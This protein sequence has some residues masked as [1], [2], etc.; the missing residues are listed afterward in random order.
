MIY[1]LDKIAQGMANDDTLLY[2]VEVSQYQ[3]VSK[4]AWIYID[5]TFFLNSLLQGS[6]LLHSNLEKIEW[7]LFASGTA[8]FK[9]HKTLHY[10]RYV[11]AP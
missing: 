6:T 4:R 5:H 9:E 7:F 2:G 11:K 1:A 8:Y 10:L 3:S